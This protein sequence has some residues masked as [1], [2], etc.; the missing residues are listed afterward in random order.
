MLGFEDPGDADC[1]NIEEILPDSVDLILCH[2]LHGGYFDLSTLPVLSRLH[3]VVL[4]MHDPWLLG[5]HCAHSFECEK[6]IDGCGDC[7][8]LNVQYSLKR[9]TSHHN[10]LRKKQIFDSCG[11]YVV[12][13][14]QWLLDKVERSILKPALIKSMVINNGV[15]QSVFCPVDKKLIREKL[16]INKDDC[17]VMFAANGIRESIWKDYATMRAAVGES[18]QAMPEKSLCFLAV[19]ESAPDEVIGS[20]T[21]SFIPYKTSE[22]LAEYYQA[23]DV[24]LHAA[25]SENFPN[26]IIEALSC[27]TPVIATAVGG[28]PEQIKGLRNEGDNCGLNH[29][30]VSEATGILT[31]VGDATALAS[32]LCHMFRNTEV[33]QQ[34]SL[35]AAIDARMRFNLEYIGNQY[36]DFFDEVIADWKSRLQVTHE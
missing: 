11:L 33:L 30:E 36:L 2:N 24:Y 35:S 6:W 19:G 23:A 31:P 8:H 28:I 34:L 3:P 1:R 20:A 21:I 9:D 14:S 18:A 4:L 25:R 12:S 22:E 26:T 5:G 7:P 29:Y 10:W 16:G 13:P 27:G 15:D 17:I 32:A